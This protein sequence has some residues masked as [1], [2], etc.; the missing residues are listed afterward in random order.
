MEQGGLQQVMQMMVEMRA[1][2]EKAARIREER[3]EREDRER[4]DRRIEKEEKREQMLY[5]REQERQREIREQ[6]QDDIRREEKLLTTLREAQPAVLQTVTINN[7]NL[8]EMKESDDVE[9]FVTLFEAALLFNT[10][11]H[12]QWKNRLHAH[13]PTKVKAKIHNVM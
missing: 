6:K 11:P 10:V 12:N 1:A 9:A 5:D 7:Q 4:E 3:R 2:D 13:L 8:P